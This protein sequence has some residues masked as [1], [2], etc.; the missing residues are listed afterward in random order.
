[1]AT[2]RTTAVTPEEK[3]VQ[4]TP[5]GGLKMDPQ[6][7]RDR[8]ERRKDWFMGEAARQA[9]N[10]ALMARCESMYDGE[11]WR[12]SDA[13]EL[14]ARGQRPVV[15]NEVKPTIDWLIGTERR[16][17]VDFLVVAE[18]PGEQASD[19]AMRKTKLLKWLDA[20]NR[21]GFE[22]SQSADDCFKAGIGWIEV[23][24]RGDKNGPPI[25]IGAE[26]WRN[27]IYDSQATKRD[28]SDGRFIFRIKVVDLDVALA[29]F[30]EKEEE[31]RACVQEGDDATI[32]RDWIIGSGLI[33]S[34]DA[35]GPSSNSDLDYLL[36]SNP[37][38][39]FNGRKRVMLIE[40]WS[41]EPVTNT[42]PNK[43]GIADP[44]TYRMVCSI[45]TERDTL[46]EAPSPF[47][48]DRFPFIPVW[49]YRN[50]RT[51][52]PYSP[53]WQL[54]GPQES[55]NH[56]M[57]RALFEASSNQLKLEKGS[58]DSEVMD[59][60]EIRA[61]LNDPNGMAIFEKGALSNG[62]VQERP[63]Q[64]EAAQQLNLAN[65][66]IQALRQMSGVTGE[67]RGLDT[68]ATS[69]KAVL[70]KQ[71]QGSMLTTELFDNL[72]FAR[73]MEGE[74]VLSLCEQ[75]LVKPM[76]V[77]TEDDKAGMEY[78]NLNQWDEESGQYVNDITARQASFKVGEQAWKQTMAESAFD[79]L[80][81]MFAQLAPVA[82]QVV[83]NILDVLFEMH[84]NLPKR[85][86]ILE[87]IRAVNGQAPLDGKLTP[88]QQAA[89]QQQQ[90]MAK[91]QFEAQ[92]AQMD[93]AIKE[94]V[95]KG[96]KLE[97]EGMAK[98]LESLYMAAQAAQVLT[99]APQIAPVAD[100]LSKSV[101]FK[102]MNGQGALNAPVQIQQAQPVPAPMQADGGMAGIQTPNADGIAV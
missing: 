6:S 89:R 82:P 54:I 63:H 70:A 99:M 72:L 10:R 27:I 37:V 30:P 92:M 79:N 81:Q 33:T 11:Q 41:R 53:I 56:R 75:Y 28:L 34:L 48:H 16:T 87:R 15:Y 68:N 47:R 85:S 71:D 13:E 100:E 23:G 95:A 45:M 35:F 83:I 43:Y 59:L 1:M 80:M 9:S 39:L 18:E 57:S 69:G 3:A 21:A 77:R 62:S 32:F 17:R 7:V 55:L 22:R 2:K 50:K 40:C 94:A 86:V 5:K 58:W 76:T 49:A 12:H 38:D 74:I 90:D 31:I 66:D 88:E 14:R 101:G 67:N 4:M 96:E 42:E 93:A 60:D 25:Y 91:R 46:L 51:G 78:V 26:S 61:E 20:T 65:H 8:H 84:P 44:I 97:A 29:C 73:Q 52:L 19:D 102:D 24:L 98:R 64:S 36:S